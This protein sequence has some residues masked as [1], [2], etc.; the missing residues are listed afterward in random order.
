MNKV[1][2]MREERSHSWEKLWSSNL[3]PCVKL[4]LWKLV[5][6][7]MP[8]SVSLRARNV[9]IDDSCRV[10]VSFIDADQHILL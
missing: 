4:F 3:S 1:C 9:D 8:Y 7:V 2:P 5:H 6:N 10:F